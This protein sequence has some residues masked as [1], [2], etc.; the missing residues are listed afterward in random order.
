MHLTQT[1]QNILFDIQS[2]RGALPHFEVLC[3]HLEA[4]LDQAQDG[5][6]TPPLGV[7]AIRSTAPDKPV[8]IA[9]AS[10]VIAVAWLAAIAE[11]VNDQDGE[12]DPAIFDDD[13]VPSF[14]DV[15]PLFEVAAACGYA[16]G[17]VRIAFAR[18]RKDGAIPRRALKILG[19]IGAIRPRKRK[20]RLRGLNRVVPLAPQFAAGLDRDEIARAKAGS[21]CYSLIARRDGYEAVRIRKT[22]TRVADD[23]AG[24]PLSV[25]SGGDA[26]LMDGFSV[27]LI[28]CESVHG[29]ALAHFVQFL[30]KPREDRPGFSYQRLVHRA[31]AA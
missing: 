8:E 31:F 24:D 26:D 16:P 15:R 1:Q 20:E 27:P 3:A 7:T 18:V 13:G 9:D 29:L 10:T 14:T 22:K 25:L 12:I 23:A 21:I 28:P 17:R 4:A 5:D 19:T 30:E 2:D 6:A 11:A